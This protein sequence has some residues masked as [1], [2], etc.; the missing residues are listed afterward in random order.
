MRP[1]KVSVVVPVYDESESLP[2]L[3]AGICRA[4]EHVRDVT[5]EILLID[6]GSR[7]RSWETIHRLHLSDA[8]IKGLR[9]S[10]N[11]GHQAA[12]TA[13]Y[14][15]ATGDAI[16][17]MD[18]D[19]QHPPEKLPQ[20]IECWRQGFEVVSMVREA[21]RHESLFK[22]VTSKAFYR[23]INAM[24]DITIRESV[25]DFRLLDRRVVRR[26]NKLGERTRFLRGLISWLGFSEI[27]IRYRPAPRFAGTSKYSIRRMVGL[28]VNAISS[29]STVPLRFAFYLGLLVSAVCIGLMGYA[30]YNSLYE[31]KDLT[32]W[33]STFMTMV[34]LGGVQL[35]M[36]GVVGIYLSRVLEEVKRRPQFVT[37]DSLGISRPRSRRSGR[38]HTPADE[39]LALEIRE[40]AHR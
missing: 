9:L 20:M 37:S 22:K 5:W 40:T 23:I 10:R 19:L 3:C 28:A 26:L 38:T 18:A 14:R 17:T 21:A 31:H 24:S 32:E 34:F 25:A 2:E 15:F 16:V 8:R 39:D 13:G 11:F 6:D 35:I 30:I 4:M 1:A 7:D 12:L 33:A 27:E 36:I 29:F